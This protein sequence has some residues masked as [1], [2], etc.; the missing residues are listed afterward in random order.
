MVYDDIDKLKTPG[1]RLKHIRNELLK[2]SRSEMFKKYGV[3]VAWSGANAAL[4]GPVSGE[5]NINDSTLKVTIKLGMMAKMAG[6]DGARLE[7]S[8]RKRLRVALD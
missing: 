7:S 3:K 2:L 8:I 1:A 4:S 5:I 6:I